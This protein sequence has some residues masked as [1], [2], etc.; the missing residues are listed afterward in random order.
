MWLPNFQGLFRSL[1]CLESMAQAQTLI[2]SR[3]PHLSLEEIEKTFKF[4]LDSFQKESVQHLLEGR[5]V[6]VCAPTGAGKT[7]IAE[8]ATI[9]ALARYRALLSNEDPTLNA[10]A[11]PN[12]A[13]SLIKI[14]KIKII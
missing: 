14:F 2:A 1:T 3:N 7:A 5:S 10:I 6:L 4:S 13:S 12:K 9:A 11:T 8:A